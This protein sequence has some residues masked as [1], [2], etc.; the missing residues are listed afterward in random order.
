MGAA[1]AVDFSLNAC[2]IA[3]SASDSLFIINFDVIA[4]AVADSYCTMGTRLV[5]PAACCALM[6]AATAAN[7]CIRSAV[8]VTAWPRLAFGT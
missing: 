7:C 5:A 4:P 1:G 2:I 3:I 6:F 8:I